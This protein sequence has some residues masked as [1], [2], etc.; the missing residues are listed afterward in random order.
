MS[1]YIKFSVL[2][3]DSFGH[4]RYK[5]VKFSSYTYMIQNQTTKNARNKLLF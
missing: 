3:R 5:N 2:N 4:F 1:Y